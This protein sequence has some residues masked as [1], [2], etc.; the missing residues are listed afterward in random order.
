MGRMDTYG[1]LRLAGL[2]DKLQRQ[3]LKDDWKAVLKGSRQLYKAASKKRH[4]YFAAYGLFMEGYILQ[5]QG[6][7]KSA[8]EKHHQSLA[9]APESELKMPNFGHLALGYSKLNRLDLAFFYVDL[10]IE[11]AEQMTAKGPR[12]EWYNFKAN[13]YF[14]AGEFNKAKR[15]AQLSIDCIPDFEE[16]PELPLLVFYQPYLTL[17][18]IAVTQKNNKRAAKLLAVLET[19][20]ELLPKP[21]LHIHA[22]KRKYRRLK[23]EFSCG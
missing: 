13:L 14:K 7:N 15:F 6:N 5:L 9:L 22:D 18:E 12:F 16:R 20:F 21:L 17:L 10:A 4:N 19:K 2:R 11:I 23:K 3:L 8:A 1:N